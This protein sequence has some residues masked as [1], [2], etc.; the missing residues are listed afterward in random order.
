[1]APAPQYNLDESIENSN[2]SEL[3]GAA[4]MFMEAAA[5]AAD[6]EDI[7]R[8]TYGDPTQDDEKM[9]LMRLLESQKPQQPWEID[10]TENSISDKSSKSSTTTTSRRRK[11]PRRSTRLGGF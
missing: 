10:V 4:D 11:P 2:W 9:R 1:M 3:N 8:I 6:L 7:A 5:Q